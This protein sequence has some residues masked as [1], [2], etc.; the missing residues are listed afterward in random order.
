ME[1]PQF[2]SSFMD[3]FWPT[4]RET[5]GANHDSRTSIW[6]SLADLA[7]KGKYTKWVW[8]P[9]K[10]Q[11]RDIR[12]GSGT[13]ARKISLYFSLFPLFLS[14]SFDLWLSLVDSIKNANYLVQYIFA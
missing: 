2:V 3:L 7:P 9:W 11:T 1:T 6:A 5:Y 8:P 4:L 12:F 13:P 10:A 14:I